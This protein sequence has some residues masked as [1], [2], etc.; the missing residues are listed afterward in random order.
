MKTRM[1]GEFWE[2][3]SHVRDALMTQN[4]EGKNVNVVEN[5]LPCVYW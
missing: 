1:V 3:Y 2:K 5:E 4:S